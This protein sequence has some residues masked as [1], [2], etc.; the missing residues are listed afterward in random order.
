MKALTHTFLVLIG[1]LTISSCTIYETEIETDVEL[2]YSS[3]IS[4]AEVDFVPEDDF[5]TVAE[6]GWDNLDEVTVDE[7][8]V[9]G[10]IRFEG[11]TAWQS[12]PLST[13]FENDVVVLRYSYDIDTFNLI[14]EGE[15]GGN[16]EANENLFD[17][18][19]LRVIAIPPTQIIRGK[20]ID[21]NNY[22]QIVDL[23]DIDFNE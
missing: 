18:D 15:V 1:I 11:T 12:L 8:L 5:V 10:Y 13:P 17:G 19:I 9:L 3:T 20:G 7:G 16:N 22:Q 21:Y 4:I 14:I 2:V 6:Y 23:Y